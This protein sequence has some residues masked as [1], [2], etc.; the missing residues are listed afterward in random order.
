[1]SISGRVDGA[2]DVY[3]VPKYVAAASIAEHG[4]PLHVNAFDGAWRMPLIVRPLADGSADAITPTF[5]GIYASPELSV[6]D[7]RQAWSKTIAELRER[8]I[9]SLVVRGS[10]AVPQAAG[11]PGLQPVSTGRPT[12]VLDLTDDAAAWNGL[13]STC[14]TRIR[15]AEKSGYTGRVRAT[16]PSDLESGSDFRTLYEGT[17]QRVGADPVYYFADAYYAALL[18]ALGSNLLMSEVI[19]GD[20]RVVSA[21]LLMRH[22]GRMHY[23]LAGSRPDDAR[24]GTNNLMMWLGIRYAIAENLHHFHIGAGATSRDGVFRF[25]ATFGGREATYDVSGAVLDEKRYDE[26][27]RLRAENCGVAVDELA[28]TGFFPAYRAGQPVTQPRSST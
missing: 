9:I 5:S 14:R 22:A 15:K 7:V 19:D 17:M 11:L 18:Q 21:C 10:A 28:A 24:R 2:P 1:M 27:V 20:G 26:L 25:K 4:E 23:H 16:A 8:R 6:R 13:R 12:I 3:F